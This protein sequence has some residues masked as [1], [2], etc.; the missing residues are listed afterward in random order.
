MLVLELTE[1]ALMN[2]VEASMARLRHLKTLGVR[3]A[4]DDF[5][6]GCS[7]LAYLRHFPTM[8]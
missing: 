4:L 3:L 7:S 1:T 6:T 5:G 8:S 2:D